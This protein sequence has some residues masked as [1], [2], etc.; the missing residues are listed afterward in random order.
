MDE[1]LISLPD[2]EVAP[3]I[4][5]G[6]RAT[7]QWKVR[8]VTP[9]WASIA[10]AEGARAVKEYF[11]VTRLC[12]ATT[13]LSDE[14]FVNLLDHPK[15]TPETLTPATQP[16]GAPDLHWRDKLHQ[17]A[18]KVAQTGLPGSDLAALSTKL[19]ALEGKEAASFLPGQMKGLFGAY[20]KGSLWFLETDPLLSHRLGALRVLMG[21]ELLPD[22]ADVLR[23]NQ[24]DHPQIRTLQEHTL[25][26]ALHFDRLVEPA[27]LAIPPASL[28]YVFPWAPHALVFLFGYPANLIQQRPTTLASLY[29]P[30]TQLAGFGSHWNAAFYESFDG[31]DAESLLQ[32]WVNRLNVIYSHATNP[33]RF[34]DPKTA[35]MRPS[36]ATAW[37]LT[38]E[39]MLADYL[40]NAAMPQGPPLARLAIAFDQLDKAESLLGFTK[41]ESGHGYQRLLRRKEMVRR[42]DAIWENRLPLQLRDAFRQHSRELYDRVYA[43]IQSETY[44][45]RLHAGGVDVWSA[46]KNRLIHRAWDNYVPVVIHSVRNSSHGLLQALASADRGVIES[47]SGKLPAELPDLVSLLTIAMVADAERLCLGEWLD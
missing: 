28:G 11:R 2:P 40:T 36:D 13:K 3:G 44:H 26:Q 32:W 1:A 21:F 35:H 4:R 6:M 10:P 16:G 30:D 38:V 18:E 20:P 47:H 25:T 15:A 43:G 41:D 22:Y 17:E 33:T 7:M 27:L 29:T 31:G 34:A 14:T 9:G 8:E 46:K 5:P 19:F 39:R 24:D 23:R 12:D 42:L 37:L 45:F